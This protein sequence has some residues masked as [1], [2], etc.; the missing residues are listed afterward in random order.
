MWGLSFLKSKNSFK[1]TASKTKTM[2]VRMP[3]ILEEAINEA[4]QMGLVSNASELIRQAL[5]D[6]LQ[7]LGILQMVI[8][9]NIAKFSKKTD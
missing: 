1:L 4:V 2:F 5:M 6:K 8:D 3:D 9:R 7:N